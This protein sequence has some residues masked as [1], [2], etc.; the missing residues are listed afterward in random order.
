M[1]IRI[2]SV[3]RPAGR[4]VELLGDELAALYRARR[5]S[6][7]RRTDPAE[8]RPAELRLR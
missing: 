7:V 5:S 6:Q 1:R 2:R 4:T 8:L 3:P